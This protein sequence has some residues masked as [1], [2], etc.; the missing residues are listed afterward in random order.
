MTTRLPRRTAQVV[1]TTTAVLA[2]AACSGPDRDATSTEPPSAAAHPSDA[3][4]TP[5]T[6]SALPA[7]EPS[8]PATPSA[9]S[10][11]HAPTSQ[12][13]TD[14]EEND[15]G[16]PQPADPRSSPDRS[17][18][19]LLAYAGGESPGIEV[20]TPADVRNLRGAPADF[21][22]FIA[23]TVRALK[24][25]STCDPAAVGIF[26]QTVRTDG[27]AVGAVDDCG[28]YQVLWTVVD[29]RWQQV[30]GT[31]DGW[32]CALL[33]RYRVPSDVSGTK[34]YDAEQGTTRDYQ[35]S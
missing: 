13:P 5:W 30:A 17:P 11:S 9:P 18:G 29:G 35:Q 16:D 4:A 7:D 15:P 1:L 21:R 25:E 12:A 31:Q 27:Y 32:R 33:R 6:P 26:V 23:R 20:R 34:C 2:L 10:T 28:G 24:A 19:R 8:T 14:P 22:R 3:P